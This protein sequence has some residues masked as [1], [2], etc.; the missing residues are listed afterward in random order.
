MS[1]KISV[2]IV[3]DAG[4]MVKALTDLLTSDM[5]I[6]VLSSA[7]DGQEALV[8]IKELKPD[9]VTL[10]VDMPVMDGIHAIRHIMIESPVPIVML[11]SLFEHGDVTF[12]ALRLGVVDFLPKPSGAVSRDIQDVKYEVIERVKIAAA[13][14]IKNV[15]RVRL[16]QWS[17]SDAI[18]DR[19]RYQSLD[20][21]IAVGTTLGGP[22]TVI[23]LMSHLPPDLP[24]SLIVVQELANGILPAFVEK[25]NTY[26]PWR[27]EQAVDNRVV[28]Q[29]VCYISSYG[30]SF[31]VAMNDENVPVLKQADASG[32]AIDQLFSSVAD[33]FGDHAIAVLLTGVGDDGK[34]GMANIKQEGGSTIA[35]SIETCVYP[36][37]TQCA[38]EL[39]VVDHIVNSDDLPARIQQLT[40]VAENGEQYI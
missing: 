8:K 24:A 18:T 4:F 14:H 32:K 20:Y 13:Q 36:N 1:D 30:Q 23:N 26:T 35:Q 33:V 2:L 22:N 27:V 19:Y 40:D 17:E 38:I 21:M 39:G 10:D 25:F 31:I 37:L 6:E 12:E 15:R 7:R 28:E 11:S 5:D 16:R 9:V 29:G 3:D 34:D